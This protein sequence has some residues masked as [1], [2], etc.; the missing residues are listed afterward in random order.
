MQNIKKWTS[1]QTSCYFSSILTLSWWYHDKAGYIAWLIMH[2]VP[3]FIHFIM[4]TIQHGSI[5]LHFQIAC[6]VDNIIFLQLLIF[7]WH[8]CTGTY[9]CSYE[10]LLIANQSLRV[11]SYSPK[12]YTIR[13]LVRVL[14]HL[15]EPQVFTGLVV[16]EE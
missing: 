2:A 7:C 16:V 3:Q 1:L 9:T 10:T 8:Y 6:W 12:N 15:I 11:Y 5:K 14:C 4:T 13:S